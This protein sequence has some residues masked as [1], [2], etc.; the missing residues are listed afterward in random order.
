MQRY[1]AEAVS[2]EKKPLKKDEASLSALG[3]CHCATGVTSRGV[4]ASSNPGVEGQILREGTNRR[5]RTGVGDEDRE[6]PAGVDQRME[7][8]SCDRIE[9]AAGEEGNAA[10]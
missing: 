7:R 8:P 4:A 5:T 10:M 2:P 6:A 9:G 1:L 3:P